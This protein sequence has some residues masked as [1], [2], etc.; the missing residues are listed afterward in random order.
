MTTSQCLRK[1]PLSEYLSRD[2]GIAVFISISIHI[3]LAA[4]LW[5]GITRH[6]AVKPNAFRDK[7]PLI[8]TLSTY[9][10][11][12]H[13]IQEPEEIPVML[14]ADLPDDLSESSQDR[15]PANELKSETDTVYLQENEE[16]T[17]LETSSD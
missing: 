7:K 14:Q 3:F 1:P 12:S 13:E 4:V 2:L 6:I 8:L 10:A 5:N 17:E 11:P 15:P 9:T 16:I